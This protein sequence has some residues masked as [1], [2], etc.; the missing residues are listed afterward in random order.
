MKNRHHL[1]M[2]FTEPVSILVDEQ[3]WIK[4]PIFQQTLTARGI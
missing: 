1:N 3:Q 2:D 4:S